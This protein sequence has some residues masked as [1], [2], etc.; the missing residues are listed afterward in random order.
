MSFSPSFVSEAPP[1]DLPPAQVAT[2]GFANSLLSSSTSSHARRYDIFI[3]RAAPEIDSCVRI[4]RSKLILP[5]PICPTPGKFTLIH[6]SAVGVFVMRVSVAHAQGRRRASAARDPVAC[7]PADAKTPSLG[8]D[9]YFGGEDDDAARRHPEELGRLRTAA[10][11]V[12]EHVC[13]PAREARARQ[14]AH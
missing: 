11:Q 2:S 1:R 10:L 12:R 6:S 5:G 14:R 4:W 8:L 7:V 3:A 13:A 9:F